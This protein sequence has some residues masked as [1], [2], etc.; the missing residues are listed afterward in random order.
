MEDVGS[1]LREWDRLSGS[2]R[3]AVILLLLILAALFFYA[4]VII[5]GKTLIGSDTVSWR[6]NAQ[7]VIAYQEATG[8]PALWAP[9]TYAGMPAYLIL[10][11]EQIPQ[12]DDVPGALRRLI[13]PASHLMV[14]LGGVYLLVFFLTRDR[15]AGLLS[16][17]AFGF[18]TY[19]PILLIAGHN[20]KFIALCFAPWMALAFVTCLRRPGFLGALLFA[21]ALAANLRAKHVQ[22]T[23]CLTFL[24]AF[25]WLVEGAHAWR[26]GRLKAFGAST[27]WLALGSVMGLSMV[28]QPYLAILEYKAFSIR[29]NG[30]PWSEAME[31]SQGPGELVTL[32]I[33]GAFGGG[34]VSYWGPK[35]FTAGPHYVGGVVA[36]LA[37][38]AVAGMNRR[39]VWAFG[40]GGVLMTLFA[41]GAYQPA[42]SRLM[43]ETL[44][45]YGAFR[46]PETWL[47]IVALALAVLAGFG[48]HYADGREGNP[49]ADKAKSR[50]IYLTTAAMLGFVLLL[51]VFD[52]AFF[53][54]R[55]PNEAEQMTEQTSATFPDAEGSEIEAAV[56]R[57]LSARM[58]R[59][60]ALFRRD[61]LRTLLFIA[62]AGAVL[63]ARRRGP[64]PGWV[65]RSA[66]AAL[67]LI[68]LW[69][70]DRRY[71]D[72][73]RFVEDGDIAAQ[74][75]TYDYD[76]YILRNQDAAGGSGHFRV[77]SLES[78]D[79]M[80]DARPSFH[81]QSLGGYHGAKLQRYQDFIDRLLV[82]PRTG[83]PDA[84]ALDMLN[85][86]YV[87]AREP[88]PDMPVVFES[89]DTELVVLENTD[90]LPRAHFVGHTKV[91]ASQEET[92]EYMRSS[93][94]DPRRTAVLPAPIDFETTPID[95]TDEA[96]AELL[97]YSPREIR[98]RVRTDAP[99]LLVASEMYY[100]AGWEAYVDGESVPIYRANYLLRA[101]PIPEGD[102]TVVMQFEPRSHRLGVRIA[103]LSTAFVYGTTLLLLLR[104]RR[105]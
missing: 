79:P 60:K 51:L 98:W 90:V 66:L 39:S 12:L 38:L 23:Y 102:H 35:A 9:N 78:G 59:R 57:Q 87:V 4:P 53:D 92:W 88:L 61:A 73:E 91:I 46:V 76:E 28:A 93:D 95:A 68:D 8:Q 74:I 22:I 11:P 17:F 47:G 2:S 7:S 42:L 69:G 10:Y 19:L 29:G 65:M 58:E 40:V 54:F 75:A 20:T 80:L 103:G 67:V 83:R 105:E 33:A 32:L 27:G 62:L 50:T 56:H 3:H 34:G 104:R 14:L 6:A 37:L 89:E 15:L 70:V 26:Q 36:L 63:A 96:V 1:E 31:W 44:P 55:R 21:I 64:L 97:D 82:D 13:W 45:F 94:F 18:T 101:V 49:D 72:E 25:W 16:A 48:V 81:H 86:R 24:L 84:T 85:A 77:L 43:H 100:P 30:L 52:D 71:I 99:R 5:T 41:L